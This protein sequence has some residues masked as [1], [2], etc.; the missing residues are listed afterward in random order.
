MLSGKK[1]RD[2]GVLKQPQQPPA[3]RADHVLLENGMEKIEVAHKSL[4]SALKA[5]NKQ[6]QRPTDPLPRRECRPAVV[7]IK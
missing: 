6:P 3:Q 5:W 4:A 2:H 7:G 1:L